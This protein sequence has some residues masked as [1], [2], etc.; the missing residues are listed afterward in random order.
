MKKLLFTVALVTLVAF[1]TTAQDQGEMRIGG[2]LALG[3]KAAI[4][5]G[6][7][8][9]GIGIN[10]GGEY[11][12]TDIISIAPSFTYFFPS[13]VEFFGQELKSQA[14]SLNIDGR[15]YF[16][17]SDMQLYG[18]AGIGVGFASAEA[19]GEKASDSKVGLN[20]G[21]GL[22]YPLSDGMFLNGQIKY[23]TPYEQL[24]INAGVLFNIGG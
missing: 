13:S 22:N 14:S 4:D 5:E 20:I 7:S 18:L 19:N 1:T 10:V 16:G 2:G 12:V 17:D 6:G 15:Y 24:V 3:T 9:A 23:N 21:G 8:K 11:F